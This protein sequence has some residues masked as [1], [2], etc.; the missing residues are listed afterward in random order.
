M[1]RKRRKGTEFTVLDAIRLATIPK[2]HQVSAIAALLIIDGEDLPMPRSQAQRIASMLVEQ[3]EERAE[4][5]GK[6]IGEVKR[7]LHLRIDRLDR[8]RRL[9]QSRAI[10][11]QLSMPERVNRVARHLFGDPAYWQSV[12]SLTPRISRPHFN[13]LHRASDGVLAG[14]VDGTV[15]GVDELITGFVYSDR[16]G[17]VR[18]ARLPVRASSVNE[19]CVL[20]GLPSRLAATTRIDW[21]RRSF[22]VAETN[23]LP[24]VLP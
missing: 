9:R 18:F 10:G 2:K 1:S 15:C 13:W 5:V 8:R 21:R 17:P 6:V 4:L 7:Q 24:W 23:H 11:S 3:P 20:M 22:V 19:L 14:G 12:G 16:G